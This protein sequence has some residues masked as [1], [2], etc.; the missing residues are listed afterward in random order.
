MASISPVLIDLPLPIRTPRLLIRS[1]QV[2]DGAVATAA[3]DET[4]DDLHTWMR[5]AESPGM[6]TAELLE[7]RNRQAMASFILRQSVEL[8]GVETATDTAVVWC[9][10]HDIDWQA[11]QCETG[12]VGSQER[13]RA[14]NCYRSRER[15]GAV[16]IRLPRNETC[17]SHPL[18][19]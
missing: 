2:G 11:K 18:S 10:L 15:D 16:R 1:K 13:P 7:I 9:G 14:R 8:I 4:W 19:R 6:L 5:W 12:V 17:W 3:I